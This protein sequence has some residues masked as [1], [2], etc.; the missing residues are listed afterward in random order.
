MGKSKA[1][2][3]IIIPA[4]NEER[5][6]KNT[7]QAAV[8]QDFPGDFEIIMV[9]NASTDNTLKVASSFKTV[10]IVCEGRKGVQF[11]RERG[12]REAKG[13]VL[14]YLDADSLPPE[15]WLKKGL[16]HFSQPDVVG[17]SGLYDYYDSQLF[18]RFLS[19]HFQKIL[20]RAAHFVVQ[21]ILHKGGVMLG[22]NSFIRASAMERIGGFNT[23][24]VF[25]GDDTD[26]A[27]RLTSVGKVLLKN[28][29]IVKS[30]SRRFKEMNIVKVT[31]I[32]ILN[33][34]WVVVFKKPFSR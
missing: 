33:F 16:A 11:A 1:K 20:F 12:R 25:Y 30:S 31:I 32:Y 4:H 14:A 28:D 7:L 3:S 34:M 23:S 17:V 9:D 21:D 27:R 15:D 19:L 22:G 29:V 6:I 13:E 8:N 10:K 18:F 26:T 5:Y 24:I 2:A